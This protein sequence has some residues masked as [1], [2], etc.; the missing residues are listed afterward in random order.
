MTHTMSAA[1]ELSRFAHAVKS[2]APAASSLSANRKLARNGL[3]GE[4]SARIVVCTGNAL[5]LADV[6]QIGR[7][8][9]WRARRDHIIEIE[10]AEARIDLGGIRRPRT[11][12]VRQSGNSEEK[13]V[14]VVRNR[15]QKDTPLRW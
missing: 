3:R 13:R 6:N 8:Q 15:L 7:S 2:A 14:W 11:A 12:R 4:L 10:V 9:F 5:L 1:P